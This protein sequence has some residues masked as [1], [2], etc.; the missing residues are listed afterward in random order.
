VKYPRPLGPR[1]TFKTGQRVP[2]DGA[3]VD[4]YGVMSHH[5]AHTTF[6]PCIGRRGECAYRKLIEAA[7]T[8]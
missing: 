4:Q 5:A 2:W 8:A 6:P 7:A 3:Y 1:G